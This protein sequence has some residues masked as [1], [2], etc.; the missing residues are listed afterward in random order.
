MKL[1]IAIPS[2]L[3]LG[4]AAYGAVSL[5]GAANQRI[6]RLQSQIAVRD[7]TIAVLQQSK[8]KIDSVYVTKTDTLR[9]VRHRTDSLLRL[10]TLLIH[11]TDTLT[12][13]RI[14]TVRQLVERERIACDAV[15]LTC[16][17]KVATRDSIIS[18]QE[19]QLKALG[20]K[21]KWLG[22]LPAPSRTLLFGV[23]LAGGYLLH[24]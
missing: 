16:E 24:R 15:V 4:A 9:I 21:D 2:V 8:R 1:P 12:R 20:R 11:R 23:G 18:L 10:D 14:D 5:Y 17:Q 3:M 13:I 19:L 22:F 6:G 7:S